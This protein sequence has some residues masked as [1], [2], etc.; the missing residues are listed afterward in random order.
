MIVYVLFLGLSFLA[1]I[2]LDLVPYELHCLI[3]L[4]PVQGEGGEG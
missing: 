3:Y 2:Y 1:F 4:T